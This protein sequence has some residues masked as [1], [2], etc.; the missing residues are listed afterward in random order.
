MNAILALNLEG[1]LRSWFL[2][3]SLTQSRA[4][5]VNTTE[6]QDCYFSW[7]EPSIQSR[8]VAA[9]AG[10]IAEVPARS[11]DQE[12]GAGKGGKTDAQPKVLP[13]AA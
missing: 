11:N 1:D 12:A 5:L 6:A 9:K 8:A 13:K 3:Q 7:S 2:L 4:T 10:M